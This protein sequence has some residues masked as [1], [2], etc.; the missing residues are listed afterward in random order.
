[1][2][3]VYELILM[4]ASAFL[5]CLALSIFIINMNDLTV[6]C[7]IVK[8]EVQTETVIHQEELDGEF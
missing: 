7:K 3:D 2:D 5:F 8:D 1:M 4:A 6:L